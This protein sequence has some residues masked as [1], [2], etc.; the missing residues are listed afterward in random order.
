ME[1]KILEKICAVADLYKN[2][3]GF[4]SA[5][6]K[7]ISLVYENE[8][9]TQA[10]IAKKSNMKKSSVSEAVTRLEKDGYVKRAVSE[11]DKR[12]V[13]VSLTK[14]GADAY[15]AINGVLCDTSKKT[16][17]RISPKDIRTLDYVLDVMIDNLK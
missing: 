9:M 4:S 16:V 5:T 14:K 8:V 10:E 1:E 6:E 12:C 3:S 13:T 7:I 2:H 15:F 11:Y 17:R